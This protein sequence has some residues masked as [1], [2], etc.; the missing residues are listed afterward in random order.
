VLISA[1][2]DADLMDPA[3]WS[4]TPALTFDTE[5][6]ADVQPSLPTGGYLE[7]DHICDNTTQTSWACPAVVYTHVRWHAAGLL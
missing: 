2:E 4:I 3:S 7:G 5:W 1:A 6:F